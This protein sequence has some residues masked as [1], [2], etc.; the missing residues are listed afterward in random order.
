V[1]SSNVDADITPKVRAMIIAL[2]GRRIDAPD[3]KERRFPLQNLRSV[4]KQVRVILEGCRATNLVCSAACGADL[5]ALSEAG[6]LGLRRRII[7]PFE[8][9]RFRSTSVTD[10]PGDWGV[11]YDEIL[12]QVEAAG[13]LIILQNTSEKNGYMAASRRILD[14]ALSM[15]E[16][17]R[18]P[19]NA[20][21]VW[22]GASRGDHD[23]TAA[24]GVDAQNLGL[25][26]LEV[27]TD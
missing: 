20:M 8:R 21:L 13:E 24:F 5:I 23:L 3:A 12:D 4:S 1:I 17:F 11:L 19:I 26:L 22:D 27:R 6:S 16:K 9:L 25:P 15:G 18:E 10:R 2:A 14:E 7:L